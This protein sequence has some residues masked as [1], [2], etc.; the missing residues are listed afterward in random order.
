MLANA[1]S[2]AYGI[3][4]LFVFRRRLFRDFHG[5]S[6]RWNF[7]AVHKVDLQLHTELLALL[8]RQPVCYSVF[9]VGEFHFSLHWNTDIASSL[10]CDFD[11]LLNCTVDHCI[12]DD[13]SFDQGT[14]AR[15]CNE[16]TRHTRHHRN[17]DFTVDSDDWRVYVFCVGDVG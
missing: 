15:I 16:C 14:R 17:D 11:R 6:V 13:S 10:H 4:S 9:S 1:R 8:F 2:N 5:L 7:V 3:V 12:R